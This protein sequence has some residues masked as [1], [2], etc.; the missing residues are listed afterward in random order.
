MAS[1]SK[2]QWTDSTWNP[3]RGCHKVSEGCKNCY[4]YRGMQRTCYDPKTPTRA[5]SVFYDPKK[6]KK[7]Y[8]PKVFVCSWSDF[9][10]KEADAPTW[11]NEAWE[12]IKLRQDL[13]FIILT[14]RPERILECLP[15]DW[16]KT[17]Y[18]NV[19]LGVSVENNKR[20][21]RIDILRQI[22]AAVKF[23]S[24]EPLLEVVDPD[25]SG[26]DWVIT[27]GESHR[28][29]K[30]C[31]YADLDWFR[32]IRDKCINEG[33]PYFHKQNGGYKKDKI[34]NAYGGRSLDGRLWEQYPFKYYE[35]FGLYLPDEMRHYRN[36]S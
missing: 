5:K 23:V 30:D 7:N 34:D 36:A 18:S 2:I 4:M 27:G 25:L 13:Q 14:K 1:N 17:G 3:W 22:P 21:Y 29:K 10:I 6:K 35:K 19:W 20:L 9:F 31:R 24:F 32:L 16:G 26:I 12:M 15:E 28:N 33:I 8:G 11:R